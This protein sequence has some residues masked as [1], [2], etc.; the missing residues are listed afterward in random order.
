LAQVKE[1]RN[2]DESLLRRRLAAL[3]DEHLLQVGE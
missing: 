2:A 3:L 1:P